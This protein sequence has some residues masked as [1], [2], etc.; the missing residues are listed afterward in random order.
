MECFLGKT[1]AHFRKWTPSDPSF[2]H[3]KKFHLSS[4]ASKY[5]TVKR[6]VK[7]FQ[8]YFG[9]FLTYENC[10]ENLSRFLFSKKSILSLGN[11]KKEL[12]WLALYTMYKLVRIVT[13]HTN[14]LPKLN[15]NYSLTIQISTKRNKNWKSKNMFENADL[16]TTHLRK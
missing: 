3:I 16:K 1:D 13:D 2:P 7:G 14:A 10:F 9:R 5:S 6:S 12:Q 8:N 15:K 11:K 4:W